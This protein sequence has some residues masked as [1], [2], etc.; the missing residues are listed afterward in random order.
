MD[1]DEDPMFS[2]SW[3]YFPC[4][5][6]ISEDLELYEP[7]GFHP[8][9]LDD[10]YDSRYRI[11]QK[12]G[13]GG[14]S[15]VWLAEDT[16]D[17]SQLSR[18]VALKIIIARESAAYE[19]HASILGDP[20]LVESE[21]LR[22][23]MFSIPKRKFWID[24]PNG[25]H[26]C[27]VLPTTGPNLASVTRGIYSRMTPALVRSVSL[28]AAQALTLLHSHGICHG[29]FTP[30]NITLSLSQDFRAYTREDVYSRFGQPLTKP[31]KTY[32]GQ[33]PRPHAPDYIVAP[34]DFFSSSTNDLLSDIHIIDFDQCFLSNSPP[35]TPLGTPAKY[36]AP[37]L[38]VGELPS[39][40]SDVWALGSLIY[41]IRTGEDLFFDYDT[42]TP[43]DVLLEII[44]VIGALPDRWAKTC[45]NDDGYPVATATNDEE[46]ADPGRPLTPPLEECTKPLREQIS[47]AKIWDAPPKGIMTITTAAAAPDSEGGDDAGGQSPEPALS[48]SGFIMP[49]EEHMQVPYPPAFDE[50]VWKPTAVCINGGYIVEYSD[51]TEEMLAAFPRISEQESTLLLDLLQRIFVYDPTERI[52]AAAMVEH[53]W[54]KLFRFVA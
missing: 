25:R 20:R 9:H 46:V 49:G 31:V 54:F 24:G 14:F 6:E 36:L 19:T 4:G 52:T 45:F 28:Q 5:L 3:K 39:P 53:P 34:L 8:V 51:E 40:A 48:G 15:T 23:G 37:E 33:S 13:S 30:S 35:K 10:L 22:S 29:D 44:K 2:P 26:L 7:G 16:A 32:S 18:W 21:L 41:K 12:L 50:M 42:N 43:V 11:V 17:E 38:A 1:S 47:A 27:L